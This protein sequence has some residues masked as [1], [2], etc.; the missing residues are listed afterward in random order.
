M[1]SWN[2]DFTVGGGGVAFTVMAGV[3]PELF[4][5]RAAVTAGTF[6]DEGIDTVAM[7]RAEPIITVAGSPVEAGGTGT[8]DLAGI[9]AV[10]SLARI[11]SLEIARVAS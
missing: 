6:V 5:G 9:G 4:P 2:G 7:S 3:R 1:S 8:D 10:G 11:R